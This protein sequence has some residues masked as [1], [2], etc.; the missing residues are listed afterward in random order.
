MNPNYATL[1]VFV[2]EKKAAVLDPC[3]QLDMC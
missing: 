3:K 2:D 1:G